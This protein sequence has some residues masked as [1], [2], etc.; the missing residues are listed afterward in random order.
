MTWF[1]YGVLAIVA[2][3]V[4]L[5]LVHGLVRELLALVSWVLAFFVA[6]A[7]AADLAPWLTA[8]SN[9]SARVM[10]AFIAIFLVVLVG[11]TLLAILFTSVVKSAGLGGINRLLGAVFGLV[12]GLA[13]VTLAVLFAGLT[14]LPAQPAW[15]QALF[16]APLEAVAQMVKVWLPYE[17][18]QHIHYDRG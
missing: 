13:V 11:M 14:S 5:S 18:A 17:L 15:R 7:F 16:S 1:D 4:L 8:V 12:R 10:L 3:S 9:T 2:F 6:R